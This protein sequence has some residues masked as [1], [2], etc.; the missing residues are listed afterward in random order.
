MRSYRGTGDQF[1]V[2]STVDSIRS[3][4]IAAWDL[5]GH[6]EEGN[7]LV[8]GTRDT[9]IVTGVPDEAAV[10]KRLDVLLSWSA[11]RIHACLPTCL[12][13]SASGQLD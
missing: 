5:I 4:H 13:G 2:N 12:D 6:E 7:P 1:F 10:L 9:R 8:L 3:R 11:P